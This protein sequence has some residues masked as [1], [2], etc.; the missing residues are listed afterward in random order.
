[1]ILD[2][3]SKNSGLGKVVRSKNGSMCIYKLTTKG[4]MENVFIE[5]PL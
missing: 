5:T 1:M 4:W 3:L 2:F